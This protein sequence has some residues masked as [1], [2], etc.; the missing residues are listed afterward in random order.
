MS[1]K[2]ILGSRVLRKEDARLVTG[3]GRF[4]SDIKLSGMVYAK[5]V[6]SPYAHAL[7]KSIDT[8]KAKSKK[9][10]IAVLTAADIKLNPVPTAWAIPNGDLK[11]PKYYPLA[12]D[13]VRYVGD[14][15]AVVVAQDP[16]T[17]R[18][19]AELV[20]VQYEPLPAVV[21][22]EEAV[23]Q[24]A[25]ELYQ[26]VPHNIAFD[27]KLSGGS[28]EAAFAAADVVI[29]HR[30]VNQ[31]LQPTPM[32][33]RAVV[34]EHS[35]H[36][37][38]YTVWV[39]SQNPHV[40]RLLFSAI[41]GIPEHKLRVIAP[42]VGGGFGSKITVY[43]DEAVIVYL[44]KVL[45]RPVYWSEDRA[46]NYS[47]ST[48]GR[49]HVQYVELAAKAD[50]TITGLRVKVYANM[51]AYLST[52]APGV[53]TYL[54]ALMLSGCYRI[55]NIHAEVVGVLTNTAPVDAYR[56][57]GRPEASYIVER[58][59]DILA[60]RL[61]KDPAEVRFRNFIPKDSMPYPTATGLSYDSGDYA[62]ALRKAME[63]VGYEKLRREQEEERKK[64][65]LIGIGISSYVEVCG[66]GPSKAVRGT[67]FGLGLWES[68]T[69]RVHPSGK[70]NVYTG[71]SPHGQG[72]ETTFAQIVSHELG[73]AFEDIEI[74]HGDTAMVPF[75]MGTYGSRTTPVGGGAIALACR[76]LVSKGTKIAAHLLDT[77]PENVVF[78]P[79][80]GAYLVRNNPERSVSIQEVAIASYQADRLPPGVEPGFEAT[81]FYDPEN[82]VFPYGTHICIVEVDAETG[83][84]MIRRYLTVDDCGTQINPMLVEGQVHGGVVQGLAQAMLEH[85]IYDSAG[86]LITATLN[87]YAL[88]TSVESPTI[89]SHFVYTPS[90]HNPLGVKGVGETGTIAA[91]QAYVNAVTDALAHLGV[92][93]IQMPLTPEKVWRSIQKK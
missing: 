91:A 31:R 50:G 70:V 82:F 45:R 62:Q 35:A 32:E 7:I 2:E 68:A 1:T 89:E 58:M 10:V 9:G 69:V 36:T 16:Y 85:A 23:K 5:F 90:P 4:T 17:S 26:D 74:I 83:H 19:A 34:A 12:S 30:F 40:H 47:S 81:R 57:A 71:S 38:T 37:D 66:L 42:D 14:P 80:R 33:T 44:S 18:D 78:D 84:V 21:E 13:K 87:E 92:Q 39:T 67:G 59:V 93:D 43:G 52:A 64:G 77:K 79:G 60:R 86:T 48:H 28:V 53:P 24:D 63:I 20:E 41:L 75:G 3:T 25:P 49:D 73:I 61:G 56:G 72:E 54:F 46:E 29:R 65:R 6:R 55:P 8:T 88:P 27:W 15:V 11:V 76:E 22:Q 51:G